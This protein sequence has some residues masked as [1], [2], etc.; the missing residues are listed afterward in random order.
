MKH[1]ISIPQLR[2]LPDARC[3]QQFLTSMGTTQ[4]SGSPPL[5]IP[6]QETGR[7]NH[8]HEQAEFTRALPTW[9]PSIRSVLPY[10]PP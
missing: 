10:L 8:H 3:A 7:Q 9:E 1:T 4:S 6:G 2:H 5:L